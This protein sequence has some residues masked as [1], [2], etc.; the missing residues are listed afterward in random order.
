V[1]NNLGRQIDIHGGGEDLIFP[2]HENEIAQSEA[3]T[4]ARPFARLWMHVA[5][6][7]LKGEKMSKSDGNM[8]F[9]RDLLKRHPADAI[10]LYLLST[11]YRRPLDFDE[12]ALSASDEQARTLA[13]ASRVP[14][15]W[16]GTENIDA[17]GRS[18]RFDEAINDDLDTPRAVQEMCGLAEELLNAADGTATYRARATLRALA[19]RLGLSLETGAP[20]R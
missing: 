2:H 6:V 10:R 4:G 18:L 12:D 9:V 11:H 20:E 16:S 14:P 13:A 19:S 1:L 8:V 17:K 7:R 5:L 15:N 3:A